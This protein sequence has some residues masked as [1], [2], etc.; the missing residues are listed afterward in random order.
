MI[1]ELYL[2]NDSIYSSRTEEN[3]N[4]LWKKLHLQSKTRIIYSCEI[5]QTAY[6]SVIVKP[7][8]KKVI[9]FY[10]NSI[11]HIIHSTNI[12]NERN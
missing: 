3:A 10:P 7:N 5:K 12:E 4:E 11:K 8:N 6:G 1:L 9:E 2:T